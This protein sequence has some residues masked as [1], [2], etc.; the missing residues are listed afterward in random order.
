MFY[1]D[2]IS[3]YNNLTCFSAFNTPAG[4]Q[5]LRSLERTIPLETSWPGIE[6]GIS[7]AV[8]TALTDSRPS[9]SAL[10]WGNHVRIRDSVPREPAQPGEIPRFFATSVVRRANLTPLDQTIS[11]TYRADRRPTCAPINSLP[12]GVQRTRRTTPPDA[13]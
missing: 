11:I 8:P 9:P 10:F 7:M 5:S 1:S 2:N 4:H 12:I 13:P 3:E 6:C